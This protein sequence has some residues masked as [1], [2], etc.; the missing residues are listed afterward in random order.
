MD[1]V[2][3]SYT[4]MTKRCHLLLAYPTRCKHLCEASNLLHLL[5]RKVH[6]VQCKGGDSMHLATAE[7]VGAGLM[8][9]SSALTP[10]VQKRNSLVPKVG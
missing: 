2:T 7:G 4:N 5:N 3:V 1:R 10:E 8:S 6:F 9:L